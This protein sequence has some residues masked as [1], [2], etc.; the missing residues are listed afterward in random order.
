ME[1]LDVCNA[2][3]SAI[4]DASY[5]RRVGASCECRREDSEEED[6]L[7]VNIFY[8]ETERDKIIRVF[9]QRYELL[10]GE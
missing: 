2:G 4:A 9:E 7:P 6:S 3:N 10:R 8:P 1:T 5:G